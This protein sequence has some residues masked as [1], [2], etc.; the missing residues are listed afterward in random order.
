MKVAIIEDEPQVAQDLKNLLIELKPNI[1]IKSILNNV[2]HSVDWLQKNSVDLL[3]MDIN[4]GTGLAF[5]IFEQIKVIT[6]VIFTTAYDSYMLQAF[7]INSIDYLLKPIDKQELSKSLEKYEQLYTNQPPIG[8][9]QIWDN[10]QNTPSPKYQTRMMV[11]S[12]EK[13]LSIKTEEIAYFFGR[14]RYV[15]LVNFKNEYYLVDFTL[16][17]LDEILNPYDFFRINRQ[18]IINFSAIKNMHT[19]FRGRIKLELTPS[20]KEETVVSAERVNRFKEWLN[21]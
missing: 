4:L 15:S 21:R 7:K 17:K 12:G 14:Q 1:E 13:I 3:F 2:S 10:L 20:T 16:D 18:F 11:V 9:K 8:W 19:Y 5:D 6:P